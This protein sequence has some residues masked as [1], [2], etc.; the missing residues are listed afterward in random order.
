LGEFKIHVEIKTEQ[1]H[2]VSNDFLIRVGEGWRNLEAGIY[3]TIEEDRMA[4]FE[5]TI[6]CLTIDTS[7]RLQNKVHIL[8]GEQTEKI[9]KS[10]SCK[11]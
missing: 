10:T 7:W 1:G 3:R 9:I 8:E 6:S 4:E 5:R 11:L 2:S